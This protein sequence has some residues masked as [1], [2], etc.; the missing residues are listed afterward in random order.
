MRV[1]QSD[2]VGDRVLD[3][4]P[5]VEL[6]PTDHLVGDLRTCQRV[7]ENPG[8]GIGPVEDGDLRSRHAFVDQAHDLTGHEPRLGVL[9]VELAELDRVARAEVRPQLLRLAAA[10]VLD[11]RVGGVEDVLGRAVVL[12]Q[13]HHVGVDEVVLE[14]EDVADVGP[15]NWYTD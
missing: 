5:L 13:A 3:L 11:H 1:D 10:V 6:G 7:L 14:L 12:L 8:L 2:Q 15:R 4:G 9:V